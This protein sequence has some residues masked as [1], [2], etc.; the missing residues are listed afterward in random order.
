M[1]LSIPAQIIKIE[2]NNEAIVQTHKNLTKINISL[3]PKLKLQD[4]IIHSNGFA[5]RKISQKEA[6]EILNILSHT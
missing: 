5:I 2:K 1:C 3:T 4:W 6:E